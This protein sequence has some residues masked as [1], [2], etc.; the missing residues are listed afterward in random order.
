MKKGASMKD[1]EM[2]Y[3]YGV[4]FTDTNLENVLWAVFETR[5]D[6]ENEAAYQNA[7]NYGNHWVERL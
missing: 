7:C 6:A 3:H 2:T 4:F 5:R 1:E